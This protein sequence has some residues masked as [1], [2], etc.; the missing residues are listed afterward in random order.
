MKYYKAMNKDFS[1]RGFQYEI[2]KTYELPKDEKLELCKNGFHFCDILN[3][4]FNYYDR[5][6]C[7]ICEVEPLGKIVRSDTYNKM[8]T[9]KIKIV[10]KLSNKEIEKERFIVQDGVIAIGE[11][12]FSG[13]TSLKSIIIPNSVTSIGDGAFYGCKSLKS[14]IIPNS[15]IIIGNCAFYNCKSLKSIT[16]P[17]SVTAIGRSAFWN[18][19]NL[20]SITIPNGVTFIGDGMFYGCTNLESITIPN[21]VTYIAYSAFDGCYNLQKIYVDKNFDI[22]ILQNHALHNKITWV[23]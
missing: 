7:I 2:G 17:D 1:C 15:V 13:Y 6:D 9:D 8:A 20:K 21:S 16:I 5:N 18:C 14:I 4:C 23:N 11:C 10:R 19:R 12:V 3:D 22:S